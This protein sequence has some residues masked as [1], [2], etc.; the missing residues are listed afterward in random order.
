M[1]NIIG[2]DTQIPTYNNCIG[3]PAQ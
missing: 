2:Q 1:T 3:L